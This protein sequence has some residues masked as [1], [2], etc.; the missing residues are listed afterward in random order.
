[1]DNKILK[2]Y[3]EDF[4]KDFA[5]SDDIE[6]FKLFEHFANFCILSKIHPESFSKII[7][8]TKQKQ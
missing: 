1:M 7:E 5:L 2:G 4:K 6:E 3:L 8:I